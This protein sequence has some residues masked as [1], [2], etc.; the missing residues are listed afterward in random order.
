MFSR[1]GNRRHFAADNEILAANCSRGRCPSG[2]A[3]EDAL[4]TVREGRGDRERE[5]DGEEA[6]SAEAS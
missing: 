1:G 5:P 4:N 3:R 2:K 6:A